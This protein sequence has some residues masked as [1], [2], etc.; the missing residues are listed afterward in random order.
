MSETGGGWIRGAGAAMACL[1]LAACATGGAGP[2]ARTGPGA[3]AAV[4]ALPE[5]FLYIEADADGDRRLT[6]EEWD[7]YV[8]AAWTAAA[9]GA[10]KIGL[11]AVRAWLQAAVGTEEAGGLVAFDPDF[12]GAVTQAEFAA[13]LAGR[14]DRQDA[15]G[16]GDLVRAELV[17][18]A[19]AGPARDRPQRP[20]ARPEGAPGPGTR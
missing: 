6:K 16:D 19:P 11:V 4:I 14:F 10:E 8:A 12:D 2:A 1:G 9:G 3:G 13:A 15:D 5:A 17:R 18:A 7:G 20:Q